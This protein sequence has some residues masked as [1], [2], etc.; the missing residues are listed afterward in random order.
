MADIQMPAHLG[1]GQVEGNGKPDTC[2]TC[3]LYDNPGIVWG[4]GP[5][6]AKIMLVGEAP[7]EEEARA[8]APFIGGSGRTLNALL[9]HAGVERSECF[10]TNVVKCRPTARDASGRTIN[11]P[12]TETEI[13]HCAR[14]LVNELHTVDPNTVV[15][16]GNIPMHTLTSAKKGIMLCR[17]VPT[18]GPKRPTL[19]TAEAT[20]VKELL[21]AQG[22]L[23]KPERFKVVGTFHPAFIM[24]AQDLWPAAVFDL[25][26]AARESAYP[27]ISRRPW[28]LTIHARPSDVLPQLEKRI[29]DLGLFHHDIETTGLDPKRDTVRCMGIAAHWDDVYVFDWTDQVQAFFRKIASD[30]R[31]MSVGQ[32]SEGFDIPFMDEKG[33]ENVGPTFDTMIGFHQLNSALPKDLGFIGA[34]VT[35]EL[36]WKDDTMYKAGEDALQRGCG[37]DIHA[38]GRAYEDQIKEME[39]LGQL[40]LYFKHI[41]PLQPVLRKMTK[42]GIRKD[43]KRA[44]GWS[45]VLNRKADELEVRLKKGLGDATFD[46]NSPKQLMDLLYNRMGLPVQYTKDRERGYRPTVDADALDAL[47]LL[48]DNPFLKLIRHIRT[49]RKWDATY[50]RCPHDE[51]CYVHPRFGSAKAATGR[52]NSWEPNAQNWPSEVREIL[53]PDNE[54]CVLLSR[55]W[56]QIEWRLAMVLSGDQTGLQALVA[57]RDAHQDAYAEAYAKEYDAVTKVERY[58]A[59]FIN[60]GLLY[61]RGEESIAAGRAGHPESAIPI[62]RV[63]DYVQKFFAKFNGYATYRDFLRDFVLQNH[64][65]ATAWGRRRWW[66]TRQLPEIYNFPMQGNAASM[67]YVALIELE[68]ELQNIS[69]LATL[70]LTVH[71]E[72]VINS[73]KDQKTLQAVQDCTREVMEKPFNLI[74]E[75]SM[76]PEVVKKLYPRGWFCPSDCHIGE[77]WRACK[78]ETDGID[79]KTG[80]R[81]GPDEFQVERDLRARLGVPA[82]GSH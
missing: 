27:A 7:G 3:P 1:P 59:K 60:Y 38:T 34:S 51:A 48:T 82:E 63:K 37:K 26:R 23:K 79:K 36:Y 73:P 39:Q 31:I 15:A 56:S 28:Q 12:P 29:Y 17:S 71:D 35:D 4:R 22:I 16:L 20:S 14:F 44:A 80:Q 40:D 43:I 11:R 42:R 41:M 67:M 33:Y 19:Q 75:S 77:N 76:R 47:A 9:A 68:R 66:Y 55:D 81:V 6:N 62:D 54:D 78:P 52:L 69:K 65:L 64:Y 13:R 53:V 45:I 5:R 46:L 8:L 61:G 50:I 32:N 25:Y 2:K 21:E 57:G 70:R 30:P 49:L 10:V 72:V 24:R 58:E 18:E 74:V